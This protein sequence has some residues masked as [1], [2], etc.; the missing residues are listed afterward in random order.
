[1]RTLS[2]N[3]CGRAVRE[4][5]HRRSGYSVGYYLMRTGTTA[6]VSLRGDDEEDEVVTFLRLVSLEEVV[7]CADCYAKPAVKRDFAHW[8]SQPAGSR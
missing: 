3:Y 2:C 8:A 5:I 6:E 1:M 4:T 7:S